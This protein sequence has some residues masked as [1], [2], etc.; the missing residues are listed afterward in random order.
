MSDCKD[1]GASQGAEAACGQAAAQDPNAVPAPKSANLTWQVGDE[2]IDY[3]AS[4]GHL[5][6]IDAQRVLEG[7]MFNLSYV[8]TSVNG[9]QVD[10]RT[11]PV[12]FAYNGGPGSASV[13]INFGGMGPRRVVTDGEGFVGADYT[14]EDNPGTLLRQ[15]D[16][17]FLDALGTGWSRVAEGYDTSRVYGLEEDARTFCRA[18]CQWLEENGRWGSPLYIF[19][20]SYGTIRSALLMRYLGEAHVPLAGVVMLSAYYDWTQ[21]L[22]GSDMGYIG[23]VPSYASTAQYFGV[24]GAGVDPDEWFDRASDFAGGEYAASLLKG[25]RVPEKEKKAV[26]KRLSRFIGLPAEYF[27]RRNNRIELEDFRRDLL[28]DRGLMCGRLDMRYSESAM[29][30]PQQASFQFAC[31][32]PANHALENAWY[33][34]FRDFCRDTLG[35][36]GPAAYRLSVWGEI[37]IHWNWVHS[38]P[39]FDAEAVAAPNVAYDIA[40]ALRRSPTTKL[41]ILGGRYDAATPWWNVDNTMARLHLPK[42]LRDGITWHRYGCGHMAYTDV[43]TLLQMTKDLDAFY[44]A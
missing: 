24:T 6:V 37:G 35:Y 5:D 43:P 28:A 14:V 27:Q 12:T 13:P 31:E 4:A 17:V 41:A 44:R 26:A 36:E 32:D 40:T 22:P 38:E 2:R 8:A 15:T 10:L 25:D 3:V 42:E 7:R 29:L 30:P 23:L 21:N 11:R 1:M 19:G 39:G 34:A 33:A 9:E 20:E 16:V 18:I